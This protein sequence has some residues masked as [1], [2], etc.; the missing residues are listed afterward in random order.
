[1]A[2]VTQVAA[3]VPVAVQ[4]SSSNSD[5]INASSGRVVVAA[6]AAVA[7]GNVAKALA[8]IDIA[9]YKAVETLEV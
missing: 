2:V 4:A 9:L 6:V 3:V 1:V 8:A 5:C 7:A